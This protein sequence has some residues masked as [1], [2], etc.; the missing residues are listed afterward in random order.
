MAP[1]QFPVRRSSRKHGDQERATRAHWYFCQ[2]LARRRHAPHR[3]RLAQPPRTTVDVSTQLRRRRSVTSHRS[4]VPLQAAGLQSL[5][6]CAERQSTPA[7]AAGCAEL[8]RTATQFVNRAAPRS[9]VNSRIRTRAAANLATCANAPSRGFKITCR[10]STTIEFTT[11]QYAR[12]AARAS[13]SRESR[14]MCFAQRR[15]RKLRQA[16][17]ARQLAKPRLLAIGCRPP[18]AGEARRLAGPAAHNNAA[19]CHEVRCGACAATAK[20][21]LWRGQPQCPQTYPRCNQS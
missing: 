8:R 5:L 6:Q 14:L 19:R 10:H 12:F 16:K 21:R 4:A 3:R 1:P 13:V 11:P 7:H 2:S 15:L 18:A 9:R 20:G 17:S